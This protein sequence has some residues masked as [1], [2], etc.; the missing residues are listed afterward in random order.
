VAAAPPP[1]EPSIA[2]RLQDVEPAHRASL[3]LA[4]VERTVRQVMQIDAGV[5]IDPAVPLRAYGL[6]SL[7][8]LEV[9][10][11]LA[12]RFARP[13]PSSLVFDHPTVEKMAQ[14]LVEM[15]TEPVARPSGTDDA[16]SADEAALESL[17]LDRLAARLAER[18]TAVLGDRS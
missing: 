1:Q 17:P 4:E 9:R 15:M 8:A 14:R 6:E 13:L 2:E 7:L 11:A 10:N 16:E 5:Q 12:M 18:V 3:V